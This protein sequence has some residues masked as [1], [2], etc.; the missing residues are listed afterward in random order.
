MYKHLMNPKNVFKA[1]LIIIALWLISGSFH[2]T[3]SSYINP[4]DYGDEG[5]NNLQY[6]GEEVAEVDDDVA[7]GE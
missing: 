5:I 4:S 2:S 7:I 1:L 6:E 3:F